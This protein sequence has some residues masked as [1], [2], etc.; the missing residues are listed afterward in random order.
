M[1]NPKLNI[2]HLV[3]RIKEHI[4]KMERGEEVEAKKDKTLLN[5]LQQQALRNALDEQKILKQNHKRPRTDAEKLAIG[6]KEIR[7]VRLEIYKQ[8]LAELEN[9]MIEHIENLQIQRETR[10][11]KIFMQAVSNAYDAGKRGPSSLSEG[12]IAL[13]RAGFKPKGTTGLTKRDKEIYE[14]EE[15]LRKQYESQLSDEDREQLQLLKESM[16]FVPKSQK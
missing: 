1:K 4:E 5:Q 15:A 11:A 2:T 12:N 9:D 7:Q 16:N 6:W 10:A 14:Q 13:I 8:A 3:P